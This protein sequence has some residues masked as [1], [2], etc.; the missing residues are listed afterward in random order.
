MLGDGKASV[1]GRGML[2]PMGCINRS[3][4]TSCEVVSNELVSIESGRSIVARAQLSSASG[5]LTSHKLEGHG[6]S[7]LIVGHDC[8]IE[9]RGILIGVGMG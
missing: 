1:G 6:N 9:G 8:G 7:I 5:K 4:R 2:G 3:S